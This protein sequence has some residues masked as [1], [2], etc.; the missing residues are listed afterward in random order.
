[1]KHSKPHKYYGRW[2]PQATGTLVFAGFAGTLFALSEILENDTDND[3]W[4][5]A[6]E[7]IAGT[8]PADETDPWD[9]DG[10][11]IADYLEFLDGTDPLDPFDPPQT[12][13]VA[14]VMNAVAPTDDEAENTSDSTTNILSLPAPTWS[15]QQNM[16]HKS[17]WFGSRLNYTFFTP[18]ADSKWQAINGTE[19]EYWSPGYYDLLARK[20]SYGI[21]ITPDELPIGEYTL[22]WKHLQRPDGCEPDYAVTVKIGEGVLATQCFTA[23]SCEKDEGG[24]S[25]SMDFPLASNNSGNVKIIF[26]PA[27]SGTKGPL[28]GTI[29]LEQKAMPAIEIVPTIEREIIEGPYEITRTTISLNGNVDEGFS[30]VFFLEKIFDI[31]DGNLVE[32]SVSSDEAATVSIDALNLTVSTSGGTASGKSDWRR[33]YGET[34]P[35]VVSYLNQGASYNLSVTITVKKSLRE[36][37]VDA[38]KNTAYELMHSRTIL[39][40]E[41]R[42]AYEKMCLEGRDFFGCGEIA[43]IKLICSFDD[44]EL[45]FNGDEE[46]SLGNEE[47]VNIRS[48]RLDLIEVQMINTQNEDLDIEIRFNDGDV[49]SKR[50]SLKVPQEEKA[51]E[52]SE[53]EYLKLNK[54]EFTPIDY[55]THRYKDGHYFLVTVY[56]LNVSFSGI[57]HWEDDYPETKSGIFNSEGLNTAHN[58]SA[59]YQLNNLHACADKVF[60]TAT[61]NESVLGFYLTSES[62]VLG[63]LIWT[64][65]VRWNVDNPGTAEKNSLLP[66]T[67]SLPSRIQTTTL[68]KNEA[69]DDAVLSV[70]KVF[71]ELTKE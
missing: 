49:I 32:V 33:D 5:D 35:V 11:G 67:G 44:S 64:C 36:L 57:Y 34:F 18:A 43:E 30:E 53:E 45:E 10:D 48:K 16:W 19:I 61:F 21:V 71:P 14:S 66:A 52:I 15:S 59:P 13:S 56:P 69:K 62:D 58:P 31:E 4:T 42:D 3:G 25:V 50:I 51:I 54:K 68:K 23:P 39:E 63:E 55:G 1:M 20:G 17:A 60:F 28:V 7:I 65:P 70:E 2:L 37:R 38:K 6:E 46:I 27:G 40:Q 8:N 29:E 12:R 24:E 41:E 9:S 22:K 26:E 47:I